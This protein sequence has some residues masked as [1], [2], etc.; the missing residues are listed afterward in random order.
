MGGG[1]SQVPATV[2]LAVDIAKQHLTLHDHLQVRRQWPV[3]TA[4]AGPGEREG[5]GGTPRGWHRIRACI[6][7]GA[8]LGTVFVGRRPTGEIW[9]PELH[10]RSPHRDWILT[11]ILWLSGVEPGYNRGGK[12]DTQRRYIYIHGTPETEP[13]GVPR[14]HGCIRMHSEALCELFEH[15][16]VGTPVWIGEGNPQR[17]GPSVS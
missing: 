1:L 9:T 5:S 6:G 13:M 4:A 11:R 17:D 12:V 2:W 7:R 15:V 8:P 10:R 14:S 16:E 3:S